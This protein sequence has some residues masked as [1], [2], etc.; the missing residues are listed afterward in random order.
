MDKATLLQAS[1]KTA[2]FFE[3]QLDEN[4]QLKEKTVCGD[5]AAQYKLPTLLLLTGRAHIAHK[6][7][8]CWFSI[9]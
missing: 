4:G 8:V 1:E 3:K 6:V 2:V 7:F 9:C 5:L